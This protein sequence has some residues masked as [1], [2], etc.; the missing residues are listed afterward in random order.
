M[1]SLA[2]GL[3][4]RQV[5]DSR[6]GG[7]LGEP[8]T[9]TTGRS[10]YSAGMPGTARRRAPGTD[11]EHEHVERRH[12]SVVLR[13]GRAA[14]QD[15]YR[16]AA[17]RGRRRRSVRARHHGYLGR[18]RH[19]RDL[20]EGRERCGPSLLL[21]GGPPELKGK[22][23]RPPTTRLAARRSR[24]WRPGRRGGELGQ[25][26]GADTAAGQHHRRGA[27]GRRPSRPAW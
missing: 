15:A 16:A 23:S 9:A 14:S 27:R 10:S 12:R 26:L 22:R 1:E 6:V 13:P 21:S 25:H 4:G 18:G 19:P 17:A 20:E 3:D 24:R 7:G 11:A 2:R 5:S 8:G